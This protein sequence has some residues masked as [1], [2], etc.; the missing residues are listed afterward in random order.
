MQVLS[1]AADAIGSRVGYAMQ[2]VYRAHD[3]HLEWTTRKTVSVT[4]KFLLQ[5]IEDP[6]MPW[7]LKR[8]V[9]KAWRTAC[10]EVTEVIVGKVVDRFGWAGE[11][12]KLE[13]YRLEGWEGSLQLN[14]LLALRARWLY[15]QMPADGSIWRVLRDPVGLAILALKLQPSTSLFAFVL[16]FVLMD[17]TDEFQLLQFILRVKAFA[18]FTDGAVPAV[19]LAH[20]YHGCIVSVAAGRPTECLARPDLVCLRAAAFTT[21]LRWQEGDR[22][23]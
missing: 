10:D 5:F 2:P 16:T 9:R 11:H 6:W 23:P 20:L 19:R 17:R 21:G 14:S 7:F 1:Q 4:H 12:R 15:A 3:R 22:G 18:A 13:R 8:F